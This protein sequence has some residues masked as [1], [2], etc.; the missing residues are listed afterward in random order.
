MTLEQKFVY[1]TTE[2]YKG[3]QFSA[4][5]ALYFAETGLA[6]G[7]YNFKLLG[8]GYDEAYGGGKTYQFTLTQAVPVGG[9]LTFPVGL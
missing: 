9:Q 1:G 4:P 7:T 2:A 5:Q 6:A 8:T 3:I